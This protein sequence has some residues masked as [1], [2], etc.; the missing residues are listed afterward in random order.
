ML[1]WKEAKTIKSRTLKELQEVLERET[2]EVERKII[3]PRSFRGA[4]GFLDAEIEADVRMMEKLRAE[5]TDMSGLSEAELETRVNGSIIERMFPTVIERYH[6]LGEQ[7]HII[8]TSLYDDYVNGVDSVA[9]ITSPEPAQNLGFEIDFTSS[10]MEMRDKVRKIGGKLEQGAVYKVKYFDSPATGK[11]K[12]LELPKVAFGLHFRDVRDFSD[13]LVEAS[14]R[15]DD[16]RLNDQIASHPVRKTF[17][18]Y[19]SAQLIQFSDIVRRQGNTAYADQH[20]RAGHYLEKL[21]KT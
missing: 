1:E 15:P 14:Y 11:I 3:N 17:L 18:Q 10:E 8:Y 13:L 4:P 16:A 2:T 5:F 20:L 21:L 7:A 6:W 12:N 9:Q 19:T